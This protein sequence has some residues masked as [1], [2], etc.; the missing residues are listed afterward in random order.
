[1]TET[2]RLRAALTRIENLLSWPAD[3]ETVPAIQ[4]L[5]TA[6]LAPVQPTPDTRPAL[7]PRQAEVLACIKQYQR[8]RGYAPDRK[9]V[10]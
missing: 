5:V 4:A 3:E 6:A 8:E 7:T 1:M 2:E 10:V 9:S